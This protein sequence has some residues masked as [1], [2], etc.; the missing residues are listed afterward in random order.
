MI[1]SGAMLE[2]LSLVGVAA[3]S[4][5]FIA[6]I[7]RGGEARFGGRR[8]LGALGF[9]Q[10]IADFLKLFAKEDFVPNH[11]SRRLYTLAPILAFGFAFCGLAF[12]PLVPAVRDEH[13]VTK[14]V[15]IES[16]YGLFWLLMLFAAGCASS[17]LGGWASNNKLSLLGGVRA[18]SRL[19]AVQVVFVLAMATL[20]MS[21][22]SARLDLIASSQNQPFLALLPQWNI[23][24]QPLG[25]VVC[26]LSGLA[27]CAAS[28]FDLVE[29]RGK[30]NLLD[31]RAEYGALK[32][33]FFIVADRIRL[34]TFAV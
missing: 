18:L 15:V 32:F 7:E 13:G 2:T 3:F 17:A 33:A 25:A 26:F 34:F 19:V 27:L 4:L 31:P 11:S 30:E 6:A 1:W 5:P 20:A 16:D 8:S 14:S 28:P 12:L 29:G 22:A 10:S 21:A 24:T 9:R 23:F